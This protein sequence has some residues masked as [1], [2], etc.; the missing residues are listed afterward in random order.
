MVS[1]TVS[2][3]SVELTARLTS[4]RAVNCSTD[5]VSS[6]VRAF[7]S[8]NRRTFSTA[9]TA[10]SAKVF[11]SSISLWENGPAPERHRNDA[12][13]STLPQHG[14]DEG[15]SPADRAGQRLMLKFRIDFTIGYVDNGA[16][17][18]RPPCSEGPGRACRE[19]AMR[20]L[21]GFGGEVVLGDQMEQLAVKLIDPAEEP[22]AQGHGASDDGVEDRLHVGRRAADHP[23]DFGGRRQ[24]AVASLQLAEESHVLDSNHG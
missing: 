4:P 21:E 5:W 23:K 1:S 11:S 2:T 18:D 9:M 8:V 13:G 15:A 17:E 10:W 14:D 12:D 19:Y 22:V 20:R 3:S 24:V 7:S 16:L 6:P